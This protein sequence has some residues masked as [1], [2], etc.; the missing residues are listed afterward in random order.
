[1]VLDKE[2]NNKAGANYIWKDIKR[3]I[4][5][6]LERAILREDLSMDW[7]SLLLYIRGN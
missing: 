2:R 1:M 5:Q 3:D 4:D 6:V 7:A